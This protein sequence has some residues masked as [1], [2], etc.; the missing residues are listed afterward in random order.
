VGGIPYSLLHNIDFGKLHV[1]FSFRS[2]KKSLF[3]GI[4]NGKIAKFG[5]ALRKNRAIIK[6]DSWTV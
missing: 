4:K 3:L 6:M 5:L 2:V 1:G